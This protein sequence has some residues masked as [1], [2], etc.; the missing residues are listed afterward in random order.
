MNLLIALSILTLSSTKFTPTNFPPK[1]LTNFIGK[2]VLLFTTKENMENLLSSALKNKETAEK[3]NKIISEQKL[4][5]SV[6]YGIY[7]DSDTWCFKSNDY[8]K[9]SLCNQY[10]PKVKSFTFFS[11]Y[12]IIYDCYS[13]QLYYLQSI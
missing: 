3:I 12:L 4:P 6:C 2:S 1:D 11:R 7:D 13:Y 5:A 9:K 8:L 10:Q